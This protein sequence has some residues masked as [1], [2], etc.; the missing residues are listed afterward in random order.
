MP[1]PAQNGMLGM[2]HW[3]AA[4]NF[5]ADHVEIHAA[6]TAARAFRDHSQAAGQALSPRW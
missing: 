1:S 2:G 6:M 5:D 3:E 4:G